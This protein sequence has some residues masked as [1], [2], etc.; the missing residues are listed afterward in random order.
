MWNERS[1][2]VLQLGFLL[3]LGL[4]ASKDVERTMQ[5]KPMTPEQVAQL[6]AMAS[7][8]NNR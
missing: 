6:K 4:I 3:A 5:Q 1:A 8:R 7:E 2:K